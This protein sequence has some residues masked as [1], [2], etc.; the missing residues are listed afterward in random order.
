VLSLK[1][2]YL[3][4]ACHLALAGIHMDAVIIYGNALEFRWLQ[5]ALRCYPKPLAAFILWRQMSPLA[6]HCRRWSPLA[7]L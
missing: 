5:W 6:G 3:H 2:L 4:I 7:Q 1:D